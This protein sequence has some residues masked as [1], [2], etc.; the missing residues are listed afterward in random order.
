M[1]GYDLGTTQKAAYEIMSYEDPIYLTVTVHCRLA[2]TAG[3]EYLTNLQLAHP[4]T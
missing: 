3:Y 2:E 4:P 1:G